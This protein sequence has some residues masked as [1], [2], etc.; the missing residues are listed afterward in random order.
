MPGTPR[1]GGIE[2]RYLA[3]R[4]QREDFFMWRC[5]RSGRGPER[6]RDQPAAGLVRARDRRSV[7]GRVRR[8][9][10]ALSSGAP[11]GRT[12]GPCRH[13][14]RLI[15]PTQSCRSRRRRAACRRSPAPMSS[16]CRSG[17][18]RAD[19]VESVGA[20]LLLCRRAHPAFSPAAVLQASRHGKA[21]RGAFARRWRGAGRTGV[22]GRQL[23][24]RAR[25]L[26]GGRSR[27]PVASVPPRALLLRSLLAELERLYNHLHYLGHLADTTTL[28]V[29][30][31][32]GKLLEERAKQ[33][34]GR[35]TGSRFLRSL[36]TP[37]GLAP[38][39]RPETVAR[40][41]ARTPAAR[42]RGLHARCWRTRTAIS[43]G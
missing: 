10:G 27:R 25:L 33:I 38:R 30:E 9:S 17:P 35:L 32:E 14:T 22:G 43:I 31:A 24:P 12:P 5:V 36:L 37:G 39:P 3:S 8:P 28:K 13:S 42:H 21:L 18:V 26:P 40:R 4:G 20:A 16:A 7:R 2:L 6:R 1:P 11:S 23:C 29:G 34:N 41:R 19:V 15:R